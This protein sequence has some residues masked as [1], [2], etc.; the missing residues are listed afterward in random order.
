MYTAETKQSFGAWHQIKQGLIVFS[1]FDRA[2]YRVKNAGPFT[3]PT[4]LFAYGV[5]VMWAP[6]IYLMHMAKN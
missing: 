5:V 1:S 3:K 2:K 4:A 6:P